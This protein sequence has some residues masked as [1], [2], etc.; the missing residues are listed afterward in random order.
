MSRS[1]VWLSLAAIALSWRCLSLSGEQ[2]DKDIIN[3]LSVEQDI[4][5]AK[6]MM[7]PMRDGTRLATDVILP[8]MK[9]DQK[10]SAVLIR[11]PYNR[12]GYVGK[13]AAENIPKLG[14]AAVVQDMRGRF[15]SEGEDFPIFGACGWGRFQD[16]YDTVEWIARQPWCDGK[17]ATVGPSAMGITQNVLLPTQPPHLTCAFIMVAAADMYREGIYWGGAPRKFLGDNWLGQNGMDRRNVDLFKA[18]PSYDELW[19]F[20]NAEKRA[21]QVNVPALYYGG[22]YD[23]FCQ[24]TINS[25]VACQNNGGAGSRGKCRLIMGPWQHGGLVDQLTYPPN[26]APKMEIWALEWFM[27]NMKG[28]DMTGGR[29]KPVMY[30]VMGACGEAGA[31]G[32][33]WRQADAWPVPSEPVCWYFH[34]GGLLSTDKPA[35]TP[36]SLSYDFD[37][38]NPVETLGG[39]NLILRRGPMDQRPVEGR[40]DVLV[41][42]TPVLTQPVEVTG[43]ITVKLWAGSSCRDTDFTGKLCDVY[44]DGRSMLVQD[45]IVRARYRESL[46]DPSLIEPG[47][48]YAYDIDLWST[49][50]LF[51]KGHRIRVAISSSNVPRFDPNPN[52]GASFDYPIDRT[53]V[54][55]N[56][57]YIDKDR[58]SHIILPRPGEKVAVR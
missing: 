11:T 13:T 20:V 1:I 5:A 16:G 25:F 40:P 46:S 2:A 3:T 50:I 8:R 23:M 21:G 44:P 52:T 38:K 45:G 58:P 12:R 14:F 9:P 51:N 34:K 53:M 18:H 43:R 57:I 55:K 39:G 7:V 31:P 33:V 10:V 37:P 30:Y 47:K 56:T 48:V 27:K 35:E 22:W 28:A 36:A 4:P 17:V 49:S 41:F 29:M 24:G 19:D 42:T 32:N 15:G 26:A 6:T 54:A